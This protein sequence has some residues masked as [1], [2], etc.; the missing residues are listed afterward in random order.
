[1]AVPSVNIQIEKGTDFSSTFTV[2]KKDSSVLNLTPYSFSAKMRK[3]AEASGY[4][5]FAATYGNDATQG[6]LTI[7]LTDTQTGIITAGRYEY[8]V[9]I[10]NLN[11]GSKTKIFAGQALVNSSLAV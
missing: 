4:V 11:N 8:D 9:I 6:N 3:H 7:S 2:K 10:T 1:M 5:G